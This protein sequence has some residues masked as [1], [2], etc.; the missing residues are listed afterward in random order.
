[1]CKMKLFTVK[2]LD[3]FTERTNGDIDF[4][5]RY[6]ANNDYG[7][8]EFLKTVDCVVLNQQYYHEHQDLYGQRYYEDIPCYVLS[9]SSFKI[10]PPAKNVHL[11]INHRMKYN[12]FFEH[13]LELQKQYENIWLAG[14]R[15]LITDCFEH[16]LIDEF[17]VID[18][19]VTI[20][21]GNT[22]ILSNSKVNNWQIVEK[23]FYDN[24]VIKV[25]YQKKNTVV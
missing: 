18:L 6:T 25:R 1:M 15:C 16:D 22:F 2:T 12:Y 9:S 24:D 21:H 19:P 14:D 5:L 20:G 10:V 17:T 11:L 8:N 4:I 7:F 13:I 23:Y 3:G